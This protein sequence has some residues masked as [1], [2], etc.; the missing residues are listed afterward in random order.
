[1]FCDEGN[2]RHTQVYLWI[3][4]LQHRLKQPIEKNDRNT[5][6]DHQRH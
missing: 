2:P 3:D 1:M 6:I 4:Q 5:L